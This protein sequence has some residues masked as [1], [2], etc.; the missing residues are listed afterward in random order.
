MKL[1]TSTVLCS[2]EKVNCTKKVSSLNS[3]LIF[4]DMFFF[5]NGELEPLNFDS[6]DPKST[7]TDW[8]MGA[9]SSCINDIAN[10][11][12]VPI[13][14]IEEV[15]EDENKRPSQYADNRKLSVNEVRTNTLSVPTIR[16]SASDNSISNILDLFDTN[17]EALEKSLLT[18]PMQASSTSLAEMKSSGSDVS[19]SFF[20]DRENIGDAYDENDFANVN[21]N[22]LS[23]QK[24]EKSNVQ[25]SLDT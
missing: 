12:F 25:F 10:D 19:I 23:E 11:D 5:Q 7:Y 24:K 15:A 18:V 3:K 16:T 8:Q 21:T 4:L 2:D 20:L 13:L 22:T 14:R 9:T 1:F 17:K 6:S